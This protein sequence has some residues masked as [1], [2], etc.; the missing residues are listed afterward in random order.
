[1][2]FAAHLPLIRALYSEIVNETFEG[3][4]PGPARYN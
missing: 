2:D 3:I 1:V 4:R